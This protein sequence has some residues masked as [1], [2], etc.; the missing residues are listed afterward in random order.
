MKG[1]VIAGLSPG[2]LKWMSHKM[3]TLSYL[4][5]GQ[6]GLLESHWYGFGDSR[7]VVSALDEAS[8]DQPGG[9]K[10]NSC[11]TPLQWILWK[12][13]PLIKL[14]RGWTSVDAASTFLSFHVYRRKILMEQQIRW[15]LV[16]IFEWWMPR[17]CKWLFAGLSN[18]GMKAC[19][20]SKPRVV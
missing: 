15:I 17:A 7:L 16:F 6:W 18:L 12:D 14:E 2:C 9:E 4:T 20:Y 5:P 3:G 11:G 19:F 8:C 1:M 10:G 13:R